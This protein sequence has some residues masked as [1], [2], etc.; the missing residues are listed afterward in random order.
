MKW[1]LF[2]KN[3]KKGFG[4]AEVLIAALVLGFTYLAL[5]H[6]QVGNRET[7]LRIRG[8]D[9]AV[10]VAQQIMDSLRTVG[11]AGLKDCKVASAEGE[12]D[13]SIE[14]TRNWGRGASVGGGVASIKYTSYVE[15]APDDN[16]KAEST[17]QYATVNH[18]YAKKA[19]VTVT[20][21]FK[22]STQSINVE[23]VIR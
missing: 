1:N 10:E 2:Q 4:I 12:D 20:W 5:L 21:K 23:G 6:L 17:S 18:V 3:N 15:F 9:G 13:C 19:L 22:H 7:L 14:V 11:I 16:Y 8:R